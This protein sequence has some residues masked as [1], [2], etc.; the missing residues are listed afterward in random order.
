MYTAVSI[1]L[2]SLRTNE[3]SRKEGLHAFLDQILSVSV[4]VN[5]HPRHLYPEIQFSIVSCLIL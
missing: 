3:P 4:V 5:R 1:E 2:P